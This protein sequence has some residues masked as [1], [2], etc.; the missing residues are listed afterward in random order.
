MDTRR[1]CHFNQIVV[2]SDNSGTTAL[3]ARQKLPGM[4]PACE[5]PAKER[6]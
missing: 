3:S 5:Q 6:H 1:R 4:Q 2:I